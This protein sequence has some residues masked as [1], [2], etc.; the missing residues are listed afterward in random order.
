MRP[1][2]FLQ[3]NTEMAEKLYGLA[4]EAAGLTGRE[5]VF[6][7]YCGAGTIGIALAGKALTVWGIE[8][9]EEAVACAIENATLNGVTNTAFFA[10]NVGQVVQEL[11]ER[12]GEP[13]VVIV[14]PP[15][16]GLAGK[17]L[18][19]TGELQALSM[20]LL[21]VQ[22]I[23][24]QTFQCLGAEGFGRVDFR[25]DP[26]GNPFVLELNSIP[27]FTATSLLPKAPQPAG[28]GFSKLCCRIMEMAHL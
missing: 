17:G 15:R 14:D 12:S 4:I 28:I 21:R 22:E 18:R 25:L 27:G 24:L 5:T 23:A 9:S 16:A 6:D 13:D 2:A 7:L 3:T 1:N 26:E 8:I 19:R 20:K 11:R 10:G